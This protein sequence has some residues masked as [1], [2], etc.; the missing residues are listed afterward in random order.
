MLDVSVKEILDAPV[1]LLRPS[2][3]AERQSLFPNSNSGW[4]YTIGLKSGQS[5]V[6]QFPSHNKREQDDPFSLDNFAFLLKPLNNLVPQ[7][8]EVKWVFEGARDSSGTRTICDVT[9]GTSEQDKFFL[10]D[11]LGSH[12]VVSP[13]SGRCVRHHHEMFVK[14]HDVYEQLMENDRLK[15]ALLVGQRRL[16]D[17]MILNDN[18]STNQMI[19]HKLDERRQND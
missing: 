2:T 19:Q 12:E 7:L 3:E 11:V 14:L 9:R 17:L 15:H 8:E 4:F 6:A 10:E 1:N 13:Y 16:G 5:F 18:N